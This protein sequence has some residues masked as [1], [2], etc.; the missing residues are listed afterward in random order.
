MKRRN[1]L[2]HTCPTV[3]FAFFGLSFIEACSKPDDEI[4]SYGTGSINSSTDTY[5][6]DV[7]TNNG[8]EKSG[9][10][11]T[12]DLTNSTFNSIVNAGDFINITSEGLLLL[13]IANTEFRSFDNC[14][15]HSGSKN[16]WSYSNE[17]FVCATHGNSF[18][19]NGNNI[20]N[21]G[22]AATSG[23]LKTYSTSLSGDSLTIT[24]S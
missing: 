20:V 12:L 22:E 15:P 17:E 11:L 13:K 19:I 16:A 14:C 10:T 7:Q 2:K 18:G 6:S 3:T 23:D 8:I 4:S 21:C 5:G 1:F 24:K 9:N